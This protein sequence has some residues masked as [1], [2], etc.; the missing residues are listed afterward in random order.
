[1]KTT[2]Q[3][4]PAELMAITITL[5]LPPKELSPNAWTPAQ[6][7]LLKAYYAQ[8]VRRGT[9]EALAKSF[10]RLKS[11]VCRKARELGLTN[12][13]RIYGQKIR[14]PKYGKEGSPELAAG[15]SI[16][17]R[18]RIAKHGHPKGMAGKTHSAATKERL[19]A[20]S[21]ETWAKT[22]RARQ[23]EITMKGLKTRLANLGTLV[24]NP[25]PH[26]TWKAG[27]REVASRRIYFRSRWEY[28]YAV[29]LQWLKSVGEIQE[30]EHE[31]ETFWFSK[32]KRGC[33]TYLPDFRVTSRDGSV[34]YHEVKGWMDARSKTKL[35]RMAKYYPDVKLRVLDSKWFSANGSILRG[36]PG[37]ERGAKDAKNPRVVLTITP[38]D[39]TE[40]LPEG[41]G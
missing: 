35:K 19:A 37:Y 23:S 16:A 8:P 36:L 33:V 27:W 40:I 21:H 12:R 7:D 32:I 25:R 17:A 39:R 14:I 5:P 34:E 2:T 29:Y 22:S 18:D 3:L 24:T 15:Q 9:L 41:E 30:W 6:L 1:M 28:N 31:P 26:A 20:T 4:S 11:N 13:K 38:A 10:G